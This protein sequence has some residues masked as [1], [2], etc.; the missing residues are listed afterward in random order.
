MSLADGSDLREG[1]TIGLPRGLHH[2]DLYPFWRTFL[3]DIGFRVVVSPPTCRRLVEQGCAAAADEACLPVKT[4][5]GH[6]M[7]L[8]WNVEAVFVPRLVSLRPGTYTCPKMLGLPDMVRQNVR[9]MP[10]VVTA[11]FDETR[12]GRGLLEA[13]VFLARRLGRSRALAKRALAKACGALRAFRGSLEAGASFDEAAGEAIRLGQA[14]PRGANRPRPAQAAPM[15]PGTD[16]PDLSP[17]AKG[18]ARRLPPRNGK[19]RV[20]VIGHSYNIFDAGVSLGLMEKLSRLEC[21]LVTSEMLTEEEVQAESSRLPKEIFWSAGRRV[22]AS[23]TK[24]R[25]EG[26][27]D[28]VVHVV[29]FG[30]GPDSMVGEIAERETRRYSDIPYLAVTIDEHTAEAGL[31]TRL[32]AFVDMLERRRR[33]TRT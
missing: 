32:E 18:C 29:S 13:G 21:H 25:R 23:A 33:R 4:F 10:R 12:P 26:L 14:T 22:L 16:R 20:G 11:D 28:G 27:V 31:V 17:E 15:D 7:D 3:E 8:R 5:Y 6:V 1:S 9:G 30:C 2:Y 19:V 24:F